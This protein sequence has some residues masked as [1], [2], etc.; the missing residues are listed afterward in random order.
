MSVFTHT[1][2]PIARKRKNEDKETNNQVIFN[3][4]HFR[5]H[6]REGVGSLYK[7]HTIIKYERQEENEDHS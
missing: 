7:N 3:H 5:S 4:L 6:Y 2:C 1:F